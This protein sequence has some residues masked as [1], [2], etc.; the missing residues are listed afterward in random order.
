[1]NWSAEAI[2][3]IEKR[4]MLLTDG[5][6]FLTGAWL[7]VAL[8]DHFKG[9]ELLER[10][11]NGPVKL[12]TTSLDA[13]TD[14]ALLKLLFERN[15]SAIFYKRFLTHDKRCQPYDFS[16]QRLVEALEKPE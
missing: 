12:A 4:E 14:P 1:L 10:S 15:Y 9:C 5:G 2:E 16:I 11:T 7:M 3:L 13:K 8:A 6:H